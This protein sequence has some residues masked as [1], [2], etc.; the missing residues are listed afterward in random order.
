MMIVCLLALVSSAIAC[1]CFPPSAE[2]AFCAANTVTGR[3]FSISCKVSSLRKEGN[4]F[5]TQLSVYG[6]EHI[7]VYKKPNDFSTLPSIVY[8]SSEELC[9]LKMEVGKEY[10]LT[11]YQARS[12][13]SNI[14]VYACGQVNDRYLTGAIEWSTVSQELRENLKK[15]Q[16]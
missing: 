13:R 16:C 12:N 11:G 6:L 9:G 14:H 5:Y 8:T 10:L 7:E 3:V 1:S 4:N 2:V 15:F